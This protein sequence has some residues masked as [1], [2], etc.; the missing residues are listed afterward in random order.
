MTTGFYLIVAVEAV[1]VIVIVATAISVVLADKCN[2]K[3][4]KEGQ[5]ENG[6]K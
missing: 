3:K 1:G 5:Q 2:A 6:R 4:Q